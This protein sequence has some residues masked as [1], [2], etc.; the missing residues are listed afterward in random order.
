MRW[1]PIR[2]TYLGFGHTMRCR[3]LAW[4]MGALLMPSLVAVAGAA[5]PPCVIPATVPVL[6]LPAVP[7]WTRGSHGVTGASVLFHFDDDAWWSQAQAYAGLRAAQ[8]GALRFPGGELADNYDWEQHA[9]ERA[10]DWPGAAATPAAREAR[11]DYREFLAHAA[12][13][14]VGQVFMVVN[15]DG[16]FRAPGDRRVNLQRYAQKA[17]RW[18]GEV[19]RAAGGMTVHWEI[20]NEPY[21]GGSFPL[22]AQEY[23]QA[24]QVFSAAMRAA[25]PSVRIGAAGPGTLN[26]IAFADRLGAAALA[27]LRA[28]AINSRRACPGLTTPACIAALQQGEPAPAPLPWWPEV[29]ARAGDSFDF[30]VIHRYARA[31]PLTPSAFPLSQRVQRLKDALQRSTGRQ[32]PLALT[33][34][35]TPSE[36]R[37][38]AL[39][40]M[41]HLLEIAIQHGNDAVAGVDYVLYWP[42]RA[43]APGHRPL[44][45]SD[46]SPTAVARLLALLHSLADADQRAQVTLAGGVY[47]L[48][49]RSGESDDYLL[50]NTGTAARVIALDAAG[51]GGW[52]VQQI[53]GDESGKAMPV[54]TCLAA[55]IHPST[56]G[57]HAPARS[58]SLIHRGPGAIG[59]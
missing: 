34:W 43:P 46:G 17:A 44:L 47:L 8:L 11:T 24:L 15:V 28:G 5:P 1:I 13:A 54:H 31:T 7:A 18:V 3:G 2:N 23:A 49:S 35:N 55:G 29:M 36:K 39:S 41:E 57:V 25:D 12:Q 9:V 10:A 37:H 32:V 33:E 48:R 19:K 6:A 52:T 27:R 38:G 16:A 40:E 21:L 51:G 53:T 56:P 30:A 42:L 50:V 45:E 20:G 58:I 26:G 22:T 4:L 59:L 14:G